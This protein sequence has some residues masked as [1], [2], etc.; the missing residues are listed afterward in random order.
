MRVQSDAAPAERGRVLREI[1]LEGL[2]QITEGLKS[3]VTGDG[4]R[5]LRGRCL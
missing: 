5:L 2:I 3:K 4:L 1:R